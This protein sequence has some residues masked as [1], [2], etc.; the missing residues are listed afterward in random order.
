MACLVQD[1]RR[2]L[3]LP[4]KDM[5]LLWSHGAFGT[6]SETSIMKHKK[7]VSEKE[8][9][10]T[11]AKKL[12]TLMEDSSLLHHGNPASMAGRKDKTPKLKSSKPTKKNMV[13]PRVNSVGKHHS[14]SRT[15]SIDGN[16]YLFL[17]NLKTP[18]NKLFRCCK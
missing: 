6:K 2:N 1:V 4:F 16:H 3:M 8:V 14:L 5:V 7:T 10:C 12:L 13:L 15:N 17:L 9:S 11:L 18:S